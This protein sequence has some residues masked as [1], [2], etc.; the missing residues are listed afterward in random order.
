VA[1]LTCPSAS[2]LATDA[3]GEFPEDRGKPR[4]PAYSVLKVTP[5]ASSAGSMTRS[6]NFVRLIG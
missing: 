2:L 5:F 6:T 1:L 3:P 4:R